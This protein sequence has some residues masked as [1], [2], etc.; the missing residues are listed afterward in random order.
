MI[1]ILK[2]P[3]QIQKKIDKLIERRE[4]LK[5]KLGTHS[6]S[7]TG[8]VQTSYEDRMADVTAEIADTD[9]EIYR[10][11]QQKCTADLEILRIA[12]C[13][14]NEDW[15]TV[16]ICHYIGGFSVED[17]GDRL[18]VSRAY[19]FKYRADAIKHLEGHPEAW[20]ST[21]GGL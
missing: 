19:A 15:Q 6:M 12:E 17:I 14:P 8:R 20:G 10:A 18:K 13:L 4:E 9:D 1:E 2:R 7:Y 16:I 11:Y 5:R 3:Y 21:P